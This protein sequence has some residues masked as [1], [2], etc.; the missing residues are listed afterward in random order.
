MPESAVRPVISHFTPSRDVTGSPCARMR[1]QRLNA[2]YC[3]MHFVYIPQQLLQ[4]A[5]R[6]YPH[7]LPL[8]RNSLLPSFQTSP[9]RP[10]VTYPPR[11]STPTAMFSTLIVAAA[12]LGGATAS[13]RHY[14]AQNQLETARLTQAAQRVEFGVEGDKSAFKFALADPVRPVLLSSSSCRIGMYRTLW[15]VPDELRLLVNGAW[16]RVRALL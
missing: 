4:S 12:F 13:S 16:R 9:R 5:S 14:D 1:L 8:I 11:A 10:F 6:T 3:C 7:L 15:A 2:A